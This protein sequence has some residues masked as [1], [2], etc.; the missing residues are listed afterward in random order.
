MVQLGC[1]YGYGWRD[2]SDA[3]GQSVKIQSTPSVAMDQ[4]MWDMIRLDEMR[5]PSTH[6]LGGGLEGVTGTLSPPLALDQSVLLVGVESWHNSFLVLAASC[7]N[8]RLR[9]RSLP[10]ICPWLDLETPSY[11]HE[12]ISPLA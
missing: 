8:E 9:I 4:R 7:D 5:P 2:G 11:S 10:C 12:K 6:G 1:S 3:G